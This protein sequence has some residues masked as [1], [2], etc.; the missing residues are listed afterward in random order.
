LRDEYAAILRGQGRRVA[1]GVIR[2]AVA[3]LT[4]AASA[5]VACKTDIELQDEMLARH[6]QRRPSAAQLLIVGLPSCRS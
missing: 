5:L 6:G 3:L 2:D 4:D 1:A